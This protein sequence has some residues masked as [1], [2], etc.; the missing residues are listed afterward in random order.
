MVDIE[1]KSYC[2]AIAEEHGAGVMFRA[3]LWTGS[4]RERE[5]RGSSKGRRRVR[6]DRHKSKW[7]R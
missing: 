7:D 1:G 2:G 6:E 4:L 5:D 3:Q